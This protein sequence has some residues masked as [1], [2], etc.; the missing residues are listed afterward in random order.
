MNGL[1]RIILDDGS[2]R[3]NPTIVPYPS[4]QLSASQTVRAGDTVNDLQGILDY[5]FSEWRLQPT[6]VPSFSQ[7][8]PRPTEPRLEERGNLLVASFNVLN[9]S[10]V[11]AWAVVSRPPVVPTTQKNSAGRLP[12]SPVP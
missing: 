10:M 6:S 8:N 3:Q 5:R 1:D 4:P 9:F 7:T 2:N 11:T 12:N